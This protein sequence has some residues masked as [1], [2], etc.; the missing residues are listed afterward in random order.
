MLFST[1]FANL[2]ST[3]T[4]YSHPHVRR[5]DPDGP[6]IGDGGAEFNVPNAEPDGPDATTLGGVALKLL[7][8]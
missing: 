6:T 8:D 4:F 1:V 7:G 2:N 3:N 5:T